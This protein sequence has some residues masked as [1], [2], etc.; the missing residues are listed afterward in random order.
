MKDIYLKTAQILHSPVINKQLASPVAQLVKNLPAMW[1]TWVQS[2]GWEN[3][4]AP[5][6]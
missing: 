5:G 6:P 1:E 2:L 4:L 3:A